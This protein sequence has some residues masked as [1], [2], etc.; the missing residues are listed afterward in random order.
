MIP[1]DYPDGGPVMRAMFE[2]N[3][4]GSLGTH[5]TDEV[6]PQTKGEQPLHMSARLWS[7]RPLHL[8][9][10]APV[11]YALEAAAVRPSSSHLTLPVRAR[12]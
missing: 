2:R 8:P 9:S 5:E 10:A 12:V 4:A 6:A 7:A 3:L 1:Q 11:P